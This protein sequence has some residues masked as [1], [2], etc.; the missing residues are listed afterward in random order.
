M[1]RKVLCLAL[2]LLMCMMVTLPTFADNEA[3]TPPERA[4]ITFSFGLTHTSGSMY[5][6][7][8]HITNL[9]GEQ[10]TVVL[11]LMNG[12]H[13]KLVSIG[14]VSSETSFYISQEV[15]LLP[16]TYYLRI[17]L[18]GNTVSRSAEKTYYI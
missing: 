4:A 8:A 3:D 11:K 12:S 10:V 1:K 9:N 16:G 17:S 6:M 7:W 13:I 5:R 18:S 14:T 2:A 15:S